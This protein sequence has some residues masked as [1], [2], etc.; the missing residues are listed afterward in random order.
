MKNKAILSL[1]CLLLTS[2]INANNLVENGDFETGGGSG[3]SRDFNVTANWYN[4][5]GKQE[6]TARRSDHNPAGSQFNALI[7][8]RAGVGTL[9]SQKT[10][11]VIRAGDT[12]EVT[13][14]SY[15]SPAS[16]HERDI[17]RLVLFAT[18]NDRLA[19]EVVWEH[20]FEKLTDVLGVW[21]TVHGVSQKVEP[22]AVGKRLFVNF[23][24]VDP[25]GNV[26]R[27]TSYARVDNIVL[28]VLK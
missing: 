11:Y 14:D 23:Y 10:G 15:C 28:K 25:K 7:T 24:G 6:A 22:P 5:G 13:F 20:N 18:E 12:F 9:H 8:D 21:E 2:S 1:F 16:W 17:I 3:A 26:D 27:S 19:G 4:R